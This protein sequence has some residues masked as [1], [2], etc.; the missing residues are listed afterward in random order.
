MNKSWRTFS[1]PIFRCITC[2]IGHSDWMGKK[3]KRL[4]AFVNPSALFSSIERSLYLR[5]IASEGMFK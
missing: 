2:S 5:A 4:A 3:T 1:T